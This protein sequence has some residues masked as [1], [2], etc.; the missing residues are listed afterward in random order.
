[1][2]TVVVAKFTYF[3]VI[4]LF[5]VLLF[6]QIY[7]M[8]NGWGSS[9]APISGTGSGVTSLSQWPMAGGRGRGFAPGRGRGGWAINN[10]EPERPVGQMPQMQQPGT[11]K[12]FG[13]GDYARSSSGGTKWGDVNMAVTN[14]HNSRNGHRHYGG[15]KNRIS[16]GCYKCGKEGHRAKE[17]NLRGCNNSVKHNK[18]N[19]VQ[20]GETEQKFEPE[21][22]LEENLYDHGVS[23]GINFSNFKNIP[24]KVTGDS[25][26]EKIEN[27]SDANLESLLLSNITKSNYATAT[28]IQAEMKTDFFLN[29]RASVALSATWF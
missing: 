13:G 9:P 12:H 28:P 20:N 10:S 23:S 8:E 26:P 1:M 2:L 7:N 24:V 6:F 3:P 21:E 15:Q 22:S 29:T 4:I 18:E 19:K 16:D 14:G 5:Y 25:V 17:C 27:F 11:N